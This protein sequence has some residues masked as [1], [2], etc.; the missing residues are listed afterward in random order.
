MKISNVLLIINMITMLYYTI[1]GAQFIAM[2]LILLIPVI[3][4]ID[5]WEVIE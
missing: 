4:S 3:M 1:T 5:N 2:V